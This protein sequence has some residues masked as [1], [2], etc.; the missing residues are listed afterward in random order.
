M[1]G[2]SRSSYK[3]LLLQVWCG[4]LTVAMV[5]M[6][7][8]LTSIKPKL[9]EVMT[10]QKFVESPTALN[11]HWE[12]LPGCNSCS[13][14]LHEDSILCK[15]DSLYFI[16]A[17]VTFTKHPN[18]SK[19]KSVILRRNT[20][21]GKSMKKLVEGIFSNTTEGSVWVAKIVSLQ[22]GDSISLDIT[23]DFLIDSTF[24]GAYQLH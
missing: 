8:F 14:S 1:E 19:A 17:Q 24:W 9:T 16:Y 7:A 5:V 3:Y 20:T 15:E 10:K 2:Q 4:L 12:V 6:A 21:Y 22:N 11:N 13:L 23:D 18:G